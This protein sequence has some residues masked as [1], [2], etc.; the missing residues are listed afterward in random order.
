M[1]WDKQCKQF[2][3]K[4]SNQCVHP[5]VPPFL[6]LYG[7]PPA[8]HPCKRKSGVTQCF[9]LHRFLFWG[10][11]RDP[12]AGDATFGTVLEDMKPLQ[13]LGL[14]RDTRKKAAILASE[15]MDPAVG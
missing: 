12:N 3:S 14:S 10:K 1:A 5:E 15:T 9:P 7:N 4:D 2:S 13:A 11:K 6:G 8:T